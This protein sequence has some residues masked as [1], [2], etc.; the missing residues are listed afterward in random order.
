MRTFEE[1]VKGRFEY[2]SKIFV[3]SASHHVGCRAPSVIP[4]AIV[5]NPRFGLQTNMKKCNEAA[6][7]RPIAHAPPPH[8]LECGLVYNTALC[9]H[10]MDRFVLYVSQLL[11]KIEWM[12]YHKIKKVIIS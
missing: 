11:Q 1:K 2:L 4:A 5:Y 8:L 7:H 6:C 10:I 9:H 12:Y 3:R